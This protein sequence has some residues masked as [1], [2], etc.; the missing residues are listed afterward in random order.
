MARFNIPNKEGFLCVG[1]ITQAHSLRGEV[2][3]KS[4]LDDTSL[5]EKGLIL[6]TADDKELKVNSVRSSNKGL[7]VKF[8]EVHNRNDAEKSRK[9]YLYLSHEEF[10]QE[11]DDEIYY[12][13]LKEY[14]LVDE[15]NNLLGNVAS[16]FDNGANTIMEIK[17]ANPVE[18][19]EKTV[20][21][22]LIPFSED[23]VLEMD[24]DEQYLVVDKELFEMY[25]NL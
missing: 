8:A 3:V 21:K 1:V 5:V 12:F 22:I 6:T 24:K 11:E 20:K 4:F 10:P 17:L 7:I 15:A 16:V 25:V 18:V 19:E 23:M 13:E 9:T 14:E 2:I